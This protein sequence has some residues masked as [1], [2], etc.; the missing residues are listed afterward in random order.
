MQMSMDEELAKKLFEEEQAKAMA[1]QEQEM[2]N[3]EAA[4]ELQK[5]L[6]N[7]EDVVL[8]L[9]NYTSSE[10]FFGVNIAESRRIQDEVFQGNEVTKT[11]GHIF[12]KVGDQISILAPM[13]LKRKRADGSLELQDLQFEGTPIEHDEKMKSV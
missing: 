6:K 3:F 5:Q 13:D 7:W 8:K 10:K 9:V 2:I 1:E 4:L 11:F 12:E